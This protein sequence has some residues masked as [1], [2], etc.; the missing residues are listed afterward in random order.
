MAVSH[1]KHDIFCSYSVVNM[2]FYVY[3]ASRA[4]QSGLH[5]GDLIIRVNGQ[6]VSRST[7]V[8]VAKIIK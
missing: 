8:S 7:S 6:N 4:E 3:T 5:S 1:N 2:L